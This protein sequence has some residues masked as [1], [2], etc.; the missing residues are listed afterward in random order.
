MKLT[1]KI[2]IDIISDVVCPWCVVGYKRLEQAMKELGVEDKFEI[3]WNPFEL[4]PNMPAEGEDII[5]HMGRK[6]NM[7][8]EQAKATQEGS[9]KTFEEVGFPFDF[10]E[11]K[12]IVNTKDAHILLDYAKEQ[13]KQTE[14]K[15]ALFKA[16]FGERKNV[17][18][19]EE[20]KLIVKSVG[21]DEEIAMARLDD[22]NAIKSVEEKEDYWKRRGVSSV[23]T[24]VFNGENA[25]N[26][27]YPVETYKQVLNEL[28]I[29]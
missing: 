1:N 23:P 14:L 5:E 7:S 11:G 21:L 8:V 22:S 2:Q 3:E 20:L 19:R 27:A 13:G 9:K 24:I 17:S 15:L 25:M 6:Y 16:N 10:Y 29:K 12:R 26:G 4:N 18:D 28:L